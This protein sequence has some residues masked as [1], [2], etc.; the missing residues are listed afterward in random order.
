MLAMPTN[1]VTVTKRHKPLFVTLLNSILPP[2]EY[3]HLRLG[4]SGL[5]TFI[6]MDDLT[7]GFF[8]WKEQ[9]L[10]RNFFEIKNLYPWKTGA[11]IGKSSAVIVEISLPNTFF[12]FAVGAQNSSPIWKDTQFWVRMERNNNMS[13]VECLHKSA[14]MWNGNYLSECLVW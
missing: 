5:L 10:E 9:N 6:L 11:C 12:I 2:L 8:C 14:F 13:L 3:G 4:I 1:T 7:K